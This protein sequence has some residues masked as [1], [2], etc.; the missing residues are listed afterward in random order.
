MRTKV[1]T[2]ISAN[3][4]HSYAKD[5]IATWV[6]N[7]DLGKESQIEIW[8]SGPFPT[9][10]VL[11]TEHGTPIHYK[12]LDVQ[13]EAWKAFNETFRNQPIPDVPD[14]EKY[15][16]RFLPFSAK[17]F[18]LAEG[19][20]LAREDKFKIDAVCWLDA[21]VKLRKTV[22][23]GDLSR[24][25]GNHSLAW[26]AR[27]ANWNYC[28]ETGF[29]LAKNDS[30]TD[31]F[32]TQANIWGSGQLFFFKEWHDAFT[33]SSLCNYFEYSDPDVFKIVNL[34]GDMRAT[35]KNGLYPFETSPL[36]EFFEHL[37][38]PLKENA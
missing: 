23:S 8:I 19:A 7:F 22:T 34:N 38:G 3:L 10:L 28:G 32:L 25:L 31:I 30:T 33:F 13:S 17:V 26:L 4:W 14:N 27:G 36:H 29:I 11:E 20:Y 18:A 1:V 12:S 37:K 5:C 6:K 21:D 15:K 24:I 16:F 35:H 9:G 2:S